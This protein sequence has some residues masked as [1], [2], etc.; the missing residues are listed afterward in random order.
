MANPQNQPDGEDRIISHVLV[1]LVVGLLV[2]RKRGIQGFL[3][4]AVAGAVGHELL[5]A[6][7]ANLVAEIT[8]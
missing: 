3:I 8:P 2:G 7:I 1:A 5:D 4:G 6:P